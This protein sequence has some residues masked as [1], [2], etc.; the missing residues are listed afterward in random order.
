MKKALLTTVLFFALAMTAAAQQE[1]FVP[2][3]ASDGLKGPV[4]VVQATRWYTYGNQDVYPYTSTD[5]YGRDGLKM[6]NTYISEVGYCETVLYWKDKQGRLTD[7]IYDGNEYGPHY[8]YSDDGRLLYICKWNYDSICK[9][10]TL[11]WATAYDKQGRTLEISDKDKPLYRYKYRSDGSLL[12]AERIDCWTIYYNKQG[13]IDSISGDHKIVYNK[14]GDEAEC[15]YY[16]HGTE[17]YN[18]GSDRDQYGNWL[19]M[20]FVRDSTHYYV[21]R[22]IIYYEDNDYSFNWK[23]IIIGSA[24]II[25]IAAILFCI[26]WKVKR[27]NNKKA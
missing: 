26:F 1:L 24:A 18:Y 14:Y 11:L 15:I 9:N 3:A 13:Q 12:S 2:T 25:A 4:Y 22:Q 19:S 20:D 6:Y 27:K 23:G 10:D 16:H 8:V 21:R 17:H 5:V 7:M